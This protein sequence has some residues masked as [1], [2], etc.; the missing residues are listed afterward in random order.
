MAFRDALDPAKGIF[1]GRVVNFFYKY[2]WLGIYSMWLK[3]TDGYP[4]VVKMYS[5]VDPRRWQGCAPL[6]G[7]K[8]FHFHAD[9]SK[10]SKI[11]G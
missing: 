6:L 3:T 5:L 4:E 11:I 7:S 2:V 10:K 8:F 1:P 9:F